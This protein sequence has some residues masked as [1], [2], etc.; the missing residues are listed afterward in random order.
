MKN[1]KL[2]H[3]CGFRYKWN[4]EMYNDKDVGDGFIFSPLDMSKNIISGLEDK[5]IEKSFFDPQFYLLN[6]YK[7]NYLSY[8]LLDEIDNIYDYM[9]V[10]NQI[11]NKCVEY[12]NSINLNFIV[13]PTIDLNLLSLNEN[14]GELYDKIKSENDEPSFINTNNKFKLLD[15]IIIDPFVNEIKKQEIEKKVLLTIIFDDEIAK[16]DSLFDSYLSQITDNDNIDGVYLIPSNIRTYKRISDINYLVKIMTFIYNLR[17]NNMDVIVGYSDIESIMYA[18]AGATG[19]SIGIYEN[20]RK[21][22]G[23]KFKNEEYNGRGPNPRV[24]SNKLFQWIEYVYLPIIKECKDLSEI[25]V[26]NS[27][28]TETQTNDYKWHFSRPHCYKH[29]MSSY[30]NLIKSLPNT[31]EERYNYI[32]NKL[33]IANDTFIELEKNIFF[34]ENSSG[35]HIN[36][37]RTALKK[38]Y[39]NVKED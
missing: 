30:S 27:Y 12:Q 19:I 28:F 23:R 1:V 22:D 15:K 29:F 18:V 14:Y 38:F 26:K 16:N 8:K 37:W 33:K 4:I 36:K 20:L 39:T 35:S 7:D 32:D 21:Y 3:Q 11:A 17:K 2:F 5:L 10:K 24:F 31:F 6:I 9:V 25:F 13:I 34:D